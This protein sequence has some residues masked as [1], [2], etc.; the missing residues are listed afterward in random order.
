MQ[1]QLRIF[2]WP[3]WW[4]ARLPHDYRFYEPNVHSYYEH[5]LPMTL[6]HFEANTQATPAP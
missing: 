6:D 5:Y 4:H 3:L 2:R 1:G